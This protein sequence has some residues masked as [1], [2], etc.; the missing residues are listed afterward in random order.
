MSIEKLDHVNIRSANVEASLQFYRD[1]LGLTATPPP[2]CTDFSKGAYFCD[3]QGNAII[4]LIAT[5]ETANSVAR[6]K[7]AAQFGMIDHF[8]L[9][10]GST[11]RALKNALDDHGVNYDAFDVDILQAHLV[12]AVDPNGINVEISFPL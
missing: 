3:G 7:G 2:T 9:R 8:A 4:H 12:F 6:V 11:A 10:G 5:T 1:I